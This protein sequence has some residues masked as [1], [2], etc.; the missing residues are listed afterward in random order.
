MD[1]DG[2]PRS[3]ERLAEAARWHNRRV[4][5]GG[6]RRGVAVRGRTFGYLQRDDVQSDDTAGYAQ[7]QYDALMRG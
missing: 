7:V 5:S 3:L 4:S 1:F 6:G 2:R